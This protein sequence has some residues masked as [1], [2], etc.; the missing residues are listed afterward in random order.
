MEKINGLKDV[1]EIIVV[2][3]GK[4]YNDYIKWKDEVNNP[5][6]IKVLNDGVDFEDK[7]L[8]MIGDMIF[9]INS[10]GIDENIMIIAGDSYF[11]FSLEQPYRFFKKEE[12]DIL[13]F[14]ELEE[15][16]EVR[17]MGVALLDSDNKII[18]YEEKSQNPVSNLCFIPIFFFKKETVKL[19]KKFDELNLNKDLSSPFISW[20]IKESKLYAFITKEK[21]LDV[22]SIKSLNLLDPKKYGSILN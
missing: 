20:L 22:G 5:I 15:I 9:A 4:Y 13:M 6:K 18:F 19:I 12:K 7:K 14:K 11:E 16:E 1:L 8:G 2:S 21:W 17:K 10:E 3:N